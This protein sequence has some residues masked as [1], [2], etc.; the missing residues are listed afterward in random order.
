MLH[1]AVASSLQVHGCSSRDGSESWLD[2]PENK[3][4]FPH[5]RP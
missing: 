5:K 3:N 4:L 1:C 2:S